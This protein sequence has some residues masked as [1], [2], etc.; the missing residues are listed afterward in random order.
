MKIIVLGQGYLGKKIANY[1][2]CQVFGNRIFTQK[3]VDDIISIEKPDVIINCIGKTGRPNIDWCEDNRQQTFFSNVVVPTYIHNSC[4]ANNAKMIHIGSGC[5][6]QGNNEGR[7]YGED[8]NPNWDGNYYAWSK[9]VSER[10]LSSFDVLQLRIRMPFFY[11]RDP[12]NLLTKLLKYTKIVEADNSIT[13]IPDMLTALKALI[14]KNATG[15]YNVVNR[16]GITHGRILHHYQKIS[17]NN[18]NYKLVDV[19]ELNNLTKVR[20][21]NCVLSLKKLDDIGIYMP[22]AIDAMERCIYNYCKNG[23]NY[24]CE[25]ID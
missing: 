18:L 12:R 4:V 3:C 9:I 24:E 15:I 1:F 17:G 6:Y 19:S 11:D 2:N 7:G 20:R 21:S 13:Y 8:D 10:Y 5:T 22:S 14:Q 25:A 23:A 16:D